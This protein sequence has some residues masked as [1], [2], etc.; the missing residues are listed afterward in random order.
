M[1]LPQVCIEPQENLCCIYENNSL[2]D[3]SPVI[4]NKKDNRACLWKP[5]VKQPSPSI[6]PIKKLFERLCTSSE[7]ESNPVDAKENVEEHN[8]SHLRKRFKLQY[9]FP[10]GEEKELV[11]LI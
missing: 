10:F 9:N 4:W 6:K 11:G 7:P 1:W 8:F 5:I 2:Q 3:K